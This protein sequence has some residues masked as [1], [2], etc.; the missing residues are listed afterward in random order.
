[1][2]EG[3][4]VVWKVLKIRCIVWLLTSLWGYLLWSVVSFLQVQCLWHM[5]LHYIYCIL[6]YVNKCNFD[7]L[8]L[9][10]SIPYHIQ[11]I[12]M[13]VS[14]LQYLSWIGWWEW[15]DRVI[16]LLETVE[17]MLSWYSVT[18]Q[19]FSVVQKLDNWTLHCIILVLSQLLWFFSCSITSSISYSCSVSPISIGKTVLETSGVSTRF[20]NTRPQQCAGSIQYT[21]NVPL[22]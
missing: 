1:M 21:I 12:I 16:I 5:W 2:H 3:V 22:M 20:M 13:R 17:H 8:S 18:W 14:F 6:S 9:V 15:G 7:T 10:H 4:R 11:V 19:C